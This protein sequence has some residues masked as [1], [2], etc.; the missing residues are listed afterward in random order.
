MATFDIDPAIQF[1]YLVTTGR[2]TG[3]P[4]EIEIWFGIDVSGVN[5]LYLLAGG[6]EKADWVRNLRKQP[7]VTVQVGDVTYGAQARV[8][9]AS[10][11]EDALARKLLVE[12]YAPSYASSLEDWGR[13]ALPVALDLVAVKPKE[14]TSS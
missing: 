2:N 9:D 14:P 5:T 4:H 7:A 13:T 8:V 11:D 1:C 3:R 10:T 6:R 12:K